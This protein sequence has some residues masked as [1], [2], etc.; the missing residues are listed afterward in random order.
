MRI[1]ITNEQN[2]VPLDEEK[3]RKAVTLLPWGK[4]KIRLSLVYVND[5]EIAK[6]NERYLKHQ[7]PTDVLSFPISENEGEIIVSGETAFEESK[8]RGI[9]AE[10][11]IILYTIHGILHLLD[12]DDK[13]PQ[14]AARM[15]AVEK[16]VITQM[17]YRWDWDA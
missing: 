10:G 14:E 2:F 12:Y 3:I 6:L 9:E 5:S 15:H 11:E 7:G 8:A 13:D 16:N 4:R 17:G 1:V